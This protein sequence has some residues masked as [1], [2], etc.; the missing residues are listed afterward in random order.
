MVENG[1]DKDKAFIW[2]YGLTRWAENLRGD[3]N[4]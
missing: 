4:E 1:Y 2:V 3:F